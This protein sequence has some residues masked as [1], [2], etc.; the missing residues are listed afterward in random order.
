[1]NQSHARKLP[2]VKLEDSIKKEHIDAFNIKL[3]HETASSYSQQSRETR[4]TRSK[5]SYEHFAKPSSARTE[6]KPNSKHII[7][8]FGK[9]MCTFA[10]STMAQPYL[11]DILKNGNIK[12]H[13]FQNYIKGKR[14]I[15]DSMKSIRDLLLVKKNDDEKLKAYKEIFQKISV[16]FIKFFSVNWI[17]QGKMTYKQAH[18]DARFKMLRRIRNPEQFTY[19][20]DFTKY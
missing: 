11:Q 16:V 1:M 4:R 19:F 14:D 8:N 13:D 7:K 9:A 10:C 3:E 12:V 20:K 5:G 6:K 18:V 2:I 17:F 15:I